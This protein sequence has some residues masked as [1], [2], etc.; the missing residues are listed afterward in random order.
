MSFLHMSLMFWLSFIFFLKLEN[1]DVK[2]KVNRS[3]EKDFH[4]IGWQGWW[5][6]NNFSKYSCKIK[7]ES[8]KILK[9]DEDYFQ[10][11]MKHNLPALVHLSPLG[12]LVAVFCV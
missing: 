10:L 2:L 5:K 3:P 8:F 6:N 7:A 12:F 4:D 9:T 1:A 11:H